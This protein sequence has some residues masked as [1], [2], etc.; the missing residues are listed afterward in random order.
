MGPN[1]ELAK[2]YEFLNIKVSLGVVSARG[3]IISGISVNSLS[4]TRWGT[5]SISQTAESKKLISSYNVF[6]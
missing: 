6:A 4:K 2:M 5:L 3:V 1:A